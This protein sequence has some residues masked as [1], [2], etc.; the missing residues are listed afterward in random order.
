MGVYGS[1]LEGVFGGVSELVKIYRMSNETLYDNFCFQKF[2]SPVN[3][4]NY[5]F[6]YPISMYSN[7]NFNSS[8]YEVLIKLFKGTDYYTAYCPGNSVLY[9]LE[10]LENLFKKNRGFGW[11]LWL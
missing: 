9:Q 7:M 1:I 4:C 6:R 5:R 2:G 11:Y 10:F 8:P 3:W